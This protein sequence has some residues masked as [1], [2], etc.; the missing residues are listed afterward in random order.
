MFRSV[1][2]QLTLDI[3][4]RDKRGRLQARRHVKCHSF[5]TNY[6]TLL[7]GLESAAFNGNGQSQSITDTGGAA[8]TIQSTGSRTV[9][10]FLTTQAL[11]TDNSYGI[12]LGRGSTA[13]DG[14]TVALA[15]LIANGNGANQMV[16]GAMGITPVGGSAPLSYTFTRTLTNNSGSTIDVTEA[17]LV[18]ACTDT[19]GVQRN[20]ATIR[21]VFAAVHVLTASNVTV[22]YT[23]SYTIA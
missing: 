4:V 20:F 5:L 23:K 22:T 1:R 15:T 6:Y 12:Q 19:G 7:Y 8:R 11:G 18:W 16:Y 21:D 17:D 14:T 3:V 9:N 10:L 13:N 2:E